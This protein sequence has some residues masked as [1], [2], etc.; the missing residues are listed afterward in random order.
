MRNGVRHFRADDEDGVRQVMEASLRFDAFPGSTAW[1]LELE[2]ASLVGDPA[3][4]AVA[5]EDGVVCG[6]VSPR[7]ENLTVLPQSRRRGHGRRL[8]DAGLGLAEKAGLDEMRLYV[9]SI[10]AAQ[11][12]ATA[13]GMTYRSSLWRLNLE[14]GTPL[15]EPSFPTDVVCRPFGHWIHIHQYVDLLNAIFVSHPSPLSFTIAEIRRAHARP[16]FDPSGIL[17]VCPADRPA[18]PVAFARTR[19]G[20]RE[21]TD[22]ARVG[23]IALVGVLPEWRGRGLGRE[24]LRWGAARLRTLGAGSVRLSVE[25]EN[26]LALRLYRRNGFRPQVEWPHWTHATRP[27]VRKP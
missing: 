27:L 2:A 20:P 22:P 12:F 6:Y 18:E 5:V 3:G 8:F 25:A 15:L 10:G 19:L 7:N 26:E 14:A 23:E 21:G 11:D 17:V 24:L 16:E 4:I 13:M 1:D 9:P